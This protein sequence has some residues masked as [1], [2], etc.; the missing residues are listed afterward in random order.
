MSQ[1]SD[2]LEP[3]KPKRETWYIILG[4]P[5]VAA[6]D[7]IMEDLG[8]PFMINPFLGINIM[9]T[10]NIWH[11]RKSIKAPWIEFF[12]TLPFAFLFIGMSLPA[13]LMGPILLFTFGSMSILMAF[14]FVRQERKKQESSN[15]LTI[16]TVIGNKK[17]NT[18]D[19]KKDRNKKH[20]GASRAYSYSPILSYYAD[21]KAIEA[22][23][24]NG[25]ASPIS[26]G[27][28][29]EILYNSNEPEEFVFAD[30]KQEQP[31]RIVSIVFITLGA[32]AVVGAAIM[33][34]L[35]L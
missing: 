20:Y 17:K 16:A 8:I 26:E 2:Q 29:M 7:K 15:V 6:F 18:T 31:F 3:P 9:L 10:I 35:S 23:Y 1:E 11:Y 13:H 28:K 22:T 12:M 27:T 33:L 30:K 14:F 34:I 32:V 25:F 21:G 5:L 19:F 24:G 4:I